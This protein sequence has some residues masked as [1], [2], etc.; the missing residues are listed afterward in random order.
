MTAQEIAGIMTMLHVAYPRYYANTKDEEKK[1]ALQ[2]WSVMFADF[3]YEIVTA[4]VKA[5]IATNKFP[6]T[7]ADINE[8][9]QLLTNTQAMS[10]LE[11]WDKVRKAICN[12]SYN[13]EEEFNKL[14]EECK[15]LVHSSHQL[16]AWAQVSE[17]E[18]NTVVASNFMRDFRSST[19]RRHEQ[20]MLPDSVKEAIGNA[21]AKKQLTEAAK[22]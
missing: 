11:A 16:K 21:A 7:V 22:Q 6:P 4:A 13:S 2:L 1:A 15:A 18:L 9:L 12:S 17:K 19:S 8:K 10:E 3:D 20:A 5:V 14:P